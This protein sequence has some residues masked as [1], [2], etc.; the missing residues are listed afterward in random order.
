MSVAPKTRVDV[1]KSVTSNVRNE[2]EE[3]GLEARLKAGGEQF[4]GDIGCYF[5]DQ[6]VAVKGDM[7]DIDVLKTV[8]DLCDEFGMEVDSERGIEFS[9]DDYAVLCM[10]WGAHE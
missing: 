6:R 2:A 7:T 9:G 5:R 3:R 4:H 8:S 10:D 1:A